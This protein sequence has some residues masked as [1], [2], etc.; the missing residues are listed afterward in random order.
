M[1]EFSKISSLSYVADG[2]FNTY[3]IPVN[4]KVVSV[5]EL[6]GKRDKK[7]IDTFL[8]AIERSLVQDFTEYYNKFDALHDCSYAEISKCNVAFSNNGGIVYSGSDIQTTDVSEL[9]CI[10]QIDLG[11]LRSFEIKDQNA[12]NS[13][14]I[15]I[16][17]SKMNMTISAQSWLYLEKI[18][19]EVLGT[20]FMTVNPTNMKL[21]F[22]LVEDEETRKTYEGIYLL[23]SE[24][25]CLGECRMTPL[26]VLISELP[27]LNGLSNFKGSLLETLKQIRY[28]CQIFIP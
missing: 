21:E 13:E 8:Y 19:N 9:Y 28:D 1:K 22:A 11:N 23:L 17:M 14:C 6:T 3:S 25:V 4:Q 27:K 24:I 20:R 7:D 10:R 26:Y 12:K 18:V 15:G 5:S 16:D 2:Q